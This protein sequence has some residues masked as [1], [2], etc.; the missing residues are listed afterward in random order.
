MLEA[1]NA[2]NA[3]YPQLQDFDF[4]DDALPLDLPVYFILGWHN[5]NATYW[6]SE[7]Y[8]L[9]EPMSE[10]KGCIGP[11]DS[12]KVNRP[13]WR[14]MPSGAPKHHFC[15]NFTINMKVPR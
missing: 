8:F 4:R 13:T 1:M 7:E 11:L 15:W 10:P 5:V 9:I 6:I 2:F 3:I 12:L 14:V